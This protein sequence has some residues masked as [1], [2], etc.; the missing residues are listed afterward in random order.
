MSTRIYDAWRGKDVGGFALSCMQ[1]ECAWGFKLKVD[2]VDGW[3]LRR[4]D[5]DRDVT[6]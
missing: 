4:G 6:G 3:E 2:E 1:V 5:G